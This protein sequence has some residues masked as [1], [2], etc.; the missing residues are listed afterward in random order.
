MPTRERLEAFVDAVTG[1]RFVQA[2]H[3][4]YHD[5]AST[6]EN[7]GPERRGVATLVA[8]EERTLQALAISAH[9]PHSVLLDGD[10]VAIQWTF[11]LTDAGGVTR[12]MEEVALQR[13]RGDRI[14]R[15]R[16]F[17][18]PDLPVLEERSPQ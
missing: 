16:F 13:W 18:D 6:R 12:R 5:D 14:E 9:R 8:I 15:E 3:D 1:G 4:F 7:G 2:L 17:Y 11:D 10:D